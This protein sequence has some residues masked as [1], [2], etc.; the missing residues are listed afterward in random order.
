MKH[1]GKA[2]CRKVKQ[3][4][5]RCW[6]I[7]FLLV[8]NFMSFYQVFYITHTKNI[9]V[10]GIYNSSLIILVSLTIATLYSIYL[11][12]QNDKLNGRGKKK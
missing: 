5:K 12:S 9:S 2:L 8:P 10:H 3:E 4:C 1:S 6:H 11:F 7:V